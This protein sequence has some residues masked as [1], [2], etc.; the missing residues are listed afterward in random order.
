MGINIDITKV[1]KY[2]DFRPKEGS[3]G[4]YYKLFDNHNNYKIYL[5]INN[6]QIDYGDRI[7]AEDSTTSNFSHDENFVVLECVIRLLECGYSPDNIILEKKWK[8]GH[9]NKGKLDILVTQKSDDS[10]YLMIECK[11]WGDEFEKEKNNMLKDGGQLFSYYQLDRGAEYL[12]LYASKLAPTIEYVSSIIKIE[13]DWKQLSNKDELFDHW[14]KNFKE[15]GIFEEGIFPYGIKSKSLCREDLIVLTKEDSSKIFDQFA[16]IL[17]QNVISDKPNAFNKIFN[18]F[19]CKIVDEDKSPDE[20]LEFQWLESDNYKTLQKR[21]NDL[22]KEGMKLFFNKTITDISDDELNEI[23]FKLS[24]SYELE[25]LK[26][27]ITDLRLQKNP[28]FAFKEVYDDKSFIDNG[29]VVK[30]IVELLQPYQLRYTHKHQFLGDFFERLLTTGLKQESGQFF[31]PVPLSQFVINCLPLENIINNNLKSN[32][33]ILPYVIDYAA[34][35]GHFLTESMDE[36]QKIIDNFDTT[37]VKESFKNKINAWKLTPYD[38]A[39]KYIYGIEADYRLIK[40]SKINCFLNGDGTAQL[41]HGDGLDNFYYSETYT[42][43]LKLNHDLMDN[44]N[45]DILITNPPYSVQAFRNTLNH[46]AGTFELFKNLSEKSSEIECLFVERAKQLLKIGGYAA[47]ILPISFLSSKDIYYDARKIILKYF[48]IKAILNLR[49]SAFMATNTKTMILFLERKN[50]NIHER[51]TY[52]INDFI[53]SPRDF[54]VN[55]IEDAFSKYVEDVFDNCNLEDYISLIK[56]DPNNNISQEYIFKG[57]KNKFGKKELDFEEIIEIEKEKMFCYFLSYP[58]TILTINPAENKKELKKFLGYSFSTTRGKEGINFDTDETNSII[59]PLFDPHNK[60][61]PKK[62]NYYVKKMFEG[63]TPDI[64]DSFD[65]IMNY[66]NLNDLIDFKNIDFIASI[67]QDLTPAINWEEIWNDSNLKYLKDI[68]IIERGTSIKESETE[69]GNIPVVRGGQTY[70]YTHNVSNRD[71]NVITVSGSG[72]Y[73]GYL[74]YWDEP[75][76]ASDCLTIISKDED[77]ISTLE[78]YNHLKKIQKIIYKFQ[79]GQAQEHVYVKDLEK[80]KIPAKY[81]KQ[82]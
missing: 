67:N 32:T 52:H 46:G 55:G 36:L 59:T 65:D 60:N 54:T 70:A 69:E 14:N 1:I 9:K 73:A 47:I 11:T 44:S 74:N 19:L 25:I 53:D 35:S 43:L 2:L 66:I 20:E 30:E 50:N 31:T 51:I 77:V 75:I 57:Y 62:V 5:D 10:P 56:Q 33:Q 12:C 16:Q 15:S 78:L 18:L 42:G 6:E 64:D 58:Q 3:K 28:E 27:K 49:D 7:I 23:F 29:K 39:E 24:D 40:T 8:V 71:A 22:Y 81:L 76:F 38:W 61:N 4:E 79:S 63:E 45:F 21:L 13:D 37:N 34:G 26:E 80:I 82:G 17:R 68:A 41:I 48:D 72:K